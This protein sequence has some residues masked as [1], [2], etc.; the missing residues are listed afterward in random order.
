M[1]WVNRLTSISLEMALPP[2]LG[3][4]LDSRW[5]TK[6]WLVATGAVLGF[7][8]AMWHLLKLAAEANGKESP[9]RPGGNES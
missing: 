1:V 8:L 4:W 9:R 3:Y 5:G 7:T 6:P 2:F